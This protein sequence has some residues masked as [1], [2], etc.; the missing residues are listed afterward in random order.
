MECILF[1]SAAWI[2]INGETPFLTH[3]LSG[4]FPVIN[5]NTVGLLGAVLFLAYFPRL[6]EAERVKVFDLAP[7][8]IGLA[9]VICSYSRISLLGVAMTAMCVLALM[10]KYKW[11]LVMALCVLIIGMDENVRSTSMDHFARGKEDRGLDDLSSNRLD[12]WDYVLDEFGASLAGRGY[13]AGFRFDKNFSAG[14]AHNSFIELYFNVGMLGIAAWLLMIGSVFYHLG[15]LLRA[16]TE[17]DYQFVSI[18]A[19]MV[20]LCFKAVAST[21]FVYLDMSMMILASVIVYIVKRQIEDEE[22]VCGT[23]MPSA[24]AIPS[25]RPN[26]A[27]MTPSDTKGVT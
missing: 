1:P 27:G 5:G 16:Q 2:K 18:I 14:H 24:S 17:T 21:V 11:I 3:A 22:A 10:R 19:V 15:K 26:P 6:F 25:L 8:V 12:M 4:V 20:F 9:S 13:A 7:C 23:V